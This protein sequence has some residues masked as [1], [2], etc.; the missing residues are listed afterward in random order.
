[1]RQIEAIIIDDL[2]GSRDA[3]TVPFSIGDEKFSLDLSAK[4][5]RE[6]RRA[7]KKFIEAAQKVS[8]PAPARA[9]PKTD[10]RKD[11]NDRVRQWAKDHKV[12]IGDRG[13]IPK[14]VVD[15][16]ETWESNH[17]NVG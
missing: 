15:Q 13:R 5:E 16:Y 14:A 4:H 6:M 9:V 3:K 12:E 1:M 7:M 8:N 10:A 2:D 17:T 11:Y